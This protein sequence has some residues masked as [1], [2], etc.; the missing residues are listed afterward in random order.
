M[1]ITDVKIYMV[2]AVWKDWVFVKTETDEGVHGIGEATIEKKARTVVTAIEQL[3]E[4]LVGKDPRKIE[5]HWQSMY[6]GAFW[7]GGPIL[8]SAISG[9]EQSLWDILGKSVG[10]PV[11]ALLG[12]ACRD[13][14]RV[15]ANQWSREAKAPAEYAEK[16]VATVEKGY[17]AL[18]W[19]PFDMV[20]FGAGGASLSRQD[21]RRVVAEVRAVREAVGEDVDLCIEVHGKLN[22]MT[23]IRM[24]RLLE[25]F[26][27]FFYEEPVPPENVDAMAK[28]AAAV[29]VPI[30]TG[31]RL[32][33]KWGYRDLL[34]KQAADIIQPDLCHDGGIL[35]TKKIAAMAE[36]YYIQVAPHN[37]NGPVST[38]ACIQLGACIPNLIIQEIY[39]NDTPPVRQEIVSDGIWV[40]SDGQITVPEKPGLG[41]ELD[42]SALKRLSVV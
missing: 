1:K 2:P 3:R 42:E 38:A 24:A 12:G 41:V 21:E 28:V 8:N 19:D 34:E 18:K 37:P 10:L 26:V 9:V 16:A 11:H 4:Y 6:S 40:E 14:I 5:A 23:A 36:T 7:R 25:E 31:E 33:T 20:S 30:A 35:E 13:R 39:P 27:P 32:F 29:D 22:T 15:Y 17:T